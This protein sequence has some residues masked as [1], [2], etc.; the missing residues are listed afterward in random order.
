M[1]EIADKNYGTIYNNDLEFL[2]GYV[3]ILNEEN[4]VP[5]DLANRACE[6]GN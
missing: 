1:Y 3:T 6:S 4:N 5:F 2:K